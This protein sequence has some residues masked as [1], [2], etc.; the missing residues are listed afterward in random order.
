MR[1]H[2]RTTGLLMAATVL[3]LSGCTTTRVAHHNPS[4]E[5]PAPPAGVVT[6]A[7]ARQALARYVVVN[8]AAN[9][10]DLAQPLQQ[11]EADPLLAIDE[12]V[13]RQVRTYSAKD[14]KQFE[15]P[16]YYTHPHFLIPAKGTATWFAAEVTGSGPAWGTPTQRL[17]IFDRGHGT[18]YKITTTVDLA[19]PLPAIA[20]D[21]HGYAR[22]AP[23]TA[24][25]ATSQ[26]AAG[27]ADLYNGSHQAVYGPS[28]ARTWVTRDTQDTAKHLAPY[29]EATYRDTTTSTPNPRLNTRTYTLATQDGGTLVITQAKV[30]M[31]VFTTTP[32]AYITPGDAETAYTGHHHLDN[33]TDD[34]TDET[35]ID[36]RPTGTARLLGLDQDLSD[37]HG[38]PTQN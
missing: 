10:K 33:L 31:S 29:A 22:L 38:N 21:H 35:A 13:D 4:A 26:L 3:L 9:A 6:L 18:T 16:F 19:S 27:I 15:K 8:N 14:R 37:A 1:S 12:Q 25:S 32:T 17:L 23:P 34:Y 20:T 11:I 2:T 5:K 7:Q 28:P 24:T 30:Q 36:L